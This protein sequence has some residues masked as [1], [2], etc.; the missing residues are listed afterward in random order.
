MDKLQVQK[1]TIAFDQPILKDLDFQ[2]E[3]GDWITLIGKSGSGKSLFLKGLARLQKLESGQILLNDQ[4]Y[5]DYAV[6]EY[7]KKVS[8]V[9]QA[10]QLFGETVR[11]NLDLPYLVRKLK[12]DPTQQL[13]GLAQMDLA[14]EYL[15]KPITELSGGQK[16][17]I[18]LLRNLLFPPTV[19]LLDEVSTGLDEDT[20]ALIWS[21]LEELHQNENNII[22]SVTHDHAE[23][24]AAKQVYT[25]EAGQMR[26][27]K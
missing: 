15:D 27:I 24:E 19:L 14:S 11:D 4:N 20:K 12:P 10:A 9:V 2:A 16:Q 23:I 18:G 13:A 7:R 8:Y 5:Q 25:F 22:L 21:V 17:R 6:E 26:K 1:M 3:S